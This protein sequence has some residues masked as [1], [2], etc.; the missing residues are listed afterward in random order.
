MDETVTL[1]GNIEPRFLKKANWNT[2][3][4]WRS[5]KPAS[6]RFTTRQGCRLENLPIDVS[7][8][9]QHLT[10]VTP[11]NLNHSGLNNWAVLKSRYGP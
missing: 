6:T 4:F 9:N 8:L 11:A 5:L 1:A 10:L 7:V 2:R 3:L